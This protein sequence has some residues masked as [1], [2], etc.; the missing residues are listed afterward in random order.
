MQAE[1]KDQASSNI[2]TARPEIA[3]T[4][5]Q[6][7]PKTPPSQRFIKVQISQYA[8]EIAADPRQ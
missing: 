3:D 4:K 8:T 7:R 5:T 2:D 6:E 1:S